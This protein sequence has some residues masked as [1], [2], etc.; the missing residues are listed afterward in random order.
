M[1]L[2]TNLQMQDI[3]KKSISNNSSYIELMAK[4]GNSIAQVVKKT[5]EIN[6]LNE[7]IL[8]LVGPGNNGGDGLIAGK[9]LCMEGYKVNIYLCTYRDSEDKLLNECIEQNISIQNVAKADF[10][11]KLQNDLSTCSIVLDAIL[12][13]NTKRTLEH[14]LKT[15]FK[16]VESERLN[17]K[18]PSILKKDPIFIIS[19]D[20]PSGINSNEETIYSHAIKADITVSLGFPKIGLFTGTGLHHSGKIINKT[21]GLLKYGANIN[22][23]VVEKEWIRSHLPVRQINSHKGDSGKVLVWAGSRKY[24]GAAYL[25]CMATMRSGSGYVTLA[26]TPKL[27]EILAA[28]M[29]EPIYHL[30]PEDTN[31]NIH[32]SEF[33]QS[34]TSLPIFDVSLLGPGIDLNQESRRFLINMIEYSNN[35]ESL[36]VIDADAL[37]I[38]S[39]TDNW[40]SNLKKAAILTPHVGEMSR[41]MKTSIQTIQ[42]NRIYYARSA[43]ME[44]G[45]YIVL[46]GPCTI[47]ADPKGNCRVIPFANPILATS[48]TGDILAGMIA[49]FASQIDDPFNAATLATYIH[50][51]IG[52]IMSEKIGA[53]GSLAGDMLPLIPFAINLLHKNE[54]IHSHIIEIEKE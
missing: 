2:V 7:K 5:I 23:E 38:L 50:S 13:I 49:S 32:V 36:S 9:I 11:S 31:G 34:V 51:V 35:L 42:S 25:S 19:V 1:K 17:R 48:G 21:I 8:I 16:L 37:T 10:M 3:E 14:A 44:W 33:S 41:L 15:I 39:Q 18:Q 40:Q 54:F 30:L 45:Q 53:I 27:Q 29:T 43:A 46:K 4:A 24:I 26:T 6:A 20:I 52:E 12:G 22:T 28:K 47:I